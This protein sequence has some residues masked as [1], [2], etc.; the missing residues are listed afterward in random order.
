MIA[1]NIILSQRNKDIDKTLRSAWDE[2]QN[3]SFVRKEQ[4]LYLAF[5]TAIAS[6]TA[7]LLSLQLTGDDQKTIPYILLFSLVLFLS[8]LLNYSYRSLTFLLRNQHEEYYK[9]NKR[10]LRYF[11]VIE[12]LGLKLTILLNAAFL[13]LMDN[14]AS[15]PLLYFI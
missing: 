8:F 14:P 5:I 10:S 11:F 15:I 12:L 7:I 3:K 13:I 9:D 6:T 1:R 4:K 2:E